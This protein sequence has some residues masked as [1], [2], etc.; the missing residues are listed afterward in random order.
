MTRARSPPPLR[1]AL[2]SML[3]IFLLSPVAEA[4]M[5]SLVQEESFTDEVI[6]AASL[7]KKSELQLATDIAPPA[8]AAVTSSIE[9]DTVL[10]AAAAEEAV[11]VS[12]EPAEALAPAEGP[13]SSD[14]V[15]MGPGASAGIEVGLSTTYHFPSFTSRGI[16]SLRSVLSLHSILE[17][18]EWNPRDVL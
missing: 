16:L 4:R 14:A 7:K 11:A 5:R 13:S 2:Y 17:G 1:L 8:D 12:A 15:A 9:V 10:P 3:A 18:K 6:D